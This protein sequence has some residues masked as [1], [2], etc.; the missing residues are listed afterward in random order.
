LGVAA[1]LLVSAVPAHAKPPD[2]KPINAKME[3]TLN[4]FQCPAEEPP[5]PGP[6]VPGPFLSWTG[7]VVIDGQTYGWA[8]EPLPVADPQPPNEKFG[9][10]EE[11]WTIFTLEHGEDPHDDP[12]LGCDS[13]RVVL[14]GDNT[15]WGPDVGFTGKARGSVTY[16]A[17]DRSPFADVELGSRMFWNGKVLGYPPAAPCCAPGTEFKATLHIT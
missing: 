16:A 7:T 3:L 2:Q 8:D 4:L 10:F 15:G 6:P 13:S 17:P 11:Y 12:S 9:Y 5:M 1:L 14:A